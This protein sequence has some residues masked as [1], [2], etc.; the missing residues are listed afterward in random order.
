M[1]SINCV[2]KLIGLI[3]SVAAITT[4]IVVFRKQICNFFKK[5][6]SFFGIEI[7]RLD[8]SYDYD[9][10]DDFADIDC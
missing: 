3:V 2:L 4:V 6:R 5:L 9:D 10:Y 7:V 1:K 8:D